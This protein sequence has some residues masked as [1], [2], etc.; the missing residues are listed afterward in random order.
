MN[1]P[2]QTGTLRDVDPHTITEDRAAEDLSLYVRW[3][4]GDTRAGSLLFRRF[5]ESLQRFFRTK[6]RPEDVDDLVQQV[7]VELSASGRR[8]TTSIRT[9]LRAYVFGVARHILCRYIRTQYRFASVDVDPLRSS[10]AALD[11]SLS[12]AI[13]EHLAAQRM[14]VALQRLPIDTQVLI[15]LRYVDGLSTAELASLYEIPVGTIKS[16]LAHARVALEE[17]TRRPTNG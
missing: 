3:N 13:G 2:D 14:V 11:P 10:I 1:H 9:T 12:T 7:W 5:S 15:E 8:S 16:R 17:E 6:S 4:A